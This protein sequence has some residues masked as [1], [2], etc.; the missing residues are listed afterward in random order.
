MGLYRVTIAGLYTYNNSLFDNMIF[1]DAANKQDFI[2]NLMLAYG[3]CE[4]LYPDWNFM[5]NSAIPAWSR[6]W[7][8][9]IDKV[10]K[11]LELTNYE[12]IENYDRHEEWT[13]SPDMTRTSQTSGQDVNRAEAGQGSTT[14]QTGADIATTDVSAFNDSNYSPSEKMTTDYG[15]STSVTANEEN[16]STFDYGRKE[17]NTETGTNK[18][19]GHIHGNIG[20]TTSQQMIQ[21]EIELRKL[22]FIDFCTGL[23]AQDL[24]LLV[25]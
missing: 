19:T 21:S 24:L 5:H 25:Y 10:Y 20:V 1:P 22:S 9:S 17:T 4:P 13:D 16:K 7:K 18:H 12:P 8:S 15:N 11:V 23:F 14:T 2:D 3:D 6:K